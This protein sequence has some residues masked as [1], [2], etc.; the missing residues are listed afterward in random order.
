MSKS[1]LAGQVFH[2]GNSREGWTATRP[3][4]ALTAVG[5]P[6]TYLVD[7]GLWKRARL[8]PFTRMAPAHLSSRIGPYWG[9][10]GIR[11]ERGEA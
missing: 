9:N 10:L 11:V 8:E 1:L 5:N 3:S 4:V 6:E 2:A 7:D